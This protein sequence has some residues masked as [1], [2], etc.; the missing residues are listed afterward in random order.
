MYCISY[1]KGQSICIPTRLVNT[2]SIFNGKLN[3]MYIGLLHLTNWIL[4]IVKVYILSVNIC[5]TF[6]I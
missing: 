2:Y 5:N 4:V 3:I 1:T 6:I